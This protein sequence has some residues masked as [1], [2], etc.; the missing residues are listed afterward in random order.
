[1]AT[2]LNLAVSP[3]VTVLFTGCLVIDGENGV[4]VGDAVGVGLAVGVGVGEA[5]G[6]GVSDGV[7]V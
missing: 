3:T 2:T 4:G 5:V 1:M 7:G 6:V